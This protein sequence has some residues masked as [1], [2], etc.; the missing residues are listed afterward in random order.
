MLSAV[1]IYKEK[2]VFKLISF[3]IAPSF[4]WVFKNIR[5][6]TACS[7]QNSKLKA[8]VWCHGPTS[9]MVVVKIQLDVNHQLLQS[10]KPLCHRFTLQPSNRELP[11]RSFSTTE[12][13]SQLRSFCFSV[14]C[15]AVCSS[16]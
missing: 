2:K 16:S 1:T 11:G 10:D 8:W 13:S 15:S 3:N 7:H 14:R 4:L 12:G 9:T 6:S 5:S